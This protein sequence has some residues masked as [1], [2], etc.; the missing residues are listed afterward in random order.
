M[1]TLI[2]FLPL[3]III[4]IFYFFMI[5]PQS[6]QQKQLQ[7]MRDNMKIGDEVITIGGFYGIV[8]AIDDKN[9]VLEMLP[10]FNKA[11]VAKSAISRVITEEESLIADDDDI[12]I[13]V[14]KD[15]DLDESSSDNGEQVEIT[16]V[17][18]EEKT[19]EEGNHKQ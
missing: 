17:T 12:D 10:D 8:Y 1:E 15:S 14:S 3:I 5:R 18:P 6:K 9:I 13:S 4:A 16:E 2:S 19:S 11:M 7:E